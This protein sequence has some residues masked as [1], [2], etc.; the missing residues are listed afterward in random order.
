MLTIA[1]EIVMKHEGFRPRPYRDTVGK[2]TIGFGRNIE[3]VGISWSEAV[4]MLE[5]DLARIEADLE[6][7]F[8]KDW[9]E[10][11]LYIKVVLVDM[12]YN[13]G[14]GGFKSFKKMI[15]AVKERDWD[16]MI[17]E[18]LD[19]KWAR[20]VPNRVKDLVKLVEVVKDGEKRSSG[21]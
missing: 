3:D 14:L 20:Q 16:K 19:S 15:R 5:N 12:C 10:L 6:E 17:A 8:G 13:L 11:P 1:K 2:L 9:E 21:D 18:M 7:F 4:F